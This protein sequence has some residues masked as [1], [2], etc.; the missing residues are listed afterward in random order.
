MKEIFLLCA[1]LVFAFPVLL[2]SAASNYGGNEGSC[3][4]E[5]T[6]HVVEVQEKPCAEEEDGD[7]TLEPEIESHPRPQRDIKY[8]IDQQLRDTGLEFE[9]YY[10]GEA[11]P[12]APT[13][14]RKRPHIEPMVFEEDE[15]QEGQEKG[16]E[17]KTEKKEGEDN[18]KARD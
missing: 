10:P 15:E 16:K 17:E 11:R 5:I 4:Q 1:L 14:R 12:I 6:E 3:E 13:Y 9:R 7:E 8:E 18:D 2:W